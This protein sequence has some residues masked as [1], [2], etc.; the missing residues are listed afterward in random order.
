[1]KYSKADSAFSDF[2][3]LRFSDERGYVKCCTCDTVRHWKEMD[4]GHFRARRHLSTRWHAQNAHAQCRFCNSEKQ[5]NLEEYAFFLI[6]RYGN[7]IIS[8]LT[9]LSQE[10][11][12]YMQWQITQ[13]ENYYREE[14]D[15]LLKEKT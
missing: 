14:A 7:D 4:C 2:I 10:S 1:M 3:R 8:Y 13:Y 9:N 12:R 11:E 5:G 6:D 15:K